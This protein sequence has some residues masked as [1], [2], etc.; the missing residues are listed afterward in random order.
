MSRHPDWEIRLNA[1]VAKHQAM[2]GEWG[3]S[4]CYMIP[5]DAVEAVIGERM[6]PAALGYKTEAGAGKKLRR[7]GFENVAQAFAARFPEIGVLMAQRG[8]IGVIERED[9]FSGGVFTAIGFMTRAHGGP[10]QFLPA[11]AV[12]RAFKVD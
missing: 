6:Y 9:Q 5:D 11:S 8:D 10:V 3:K 1:V 4:D 2:P 7:H 12:T